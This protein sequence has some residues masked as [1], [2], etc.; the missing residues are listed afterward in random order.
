MNTSHARP[1]KILNA[2]AGSGKT[3]HLVKEYLS[4]LINDDAPANSFSHVIAMTFTNKAALEM[5]ERII[6]A[7][8][9]IASPDYFQ[10]RADALTQELSK[11]LNLDPERIRERCKESL[12]SILHQYEEFHVM[13]ID[14]FNLRLIK[15]FVRDL[16]LPS[17]FEVI[18]DE[19][20]L[21]EIIVDNLLSQLGTDGSK[22]LNRLVFQY[23][24]TNIEEGVQ[25]NFRQ[26]LIEFGAVLK[27]ERNTKTIEQLMEMDFSI[28]QFGRI[29]SQLKEIDSQFLQLANKL[30]D[31]IQVNSL[32]SDQLP[33]KSYTY[34]AILDLHNH[35]RFPIDKKPLVSDS[36]LKNLNIELKKGQWYPDEIKTAIRALLQ[37]W[38]DHFENYI[39]LHLFRQNFFNMALLK[40]IAEALANAR[41]EQQL[42]RISEFNTLISQLIQNESTPFIYERLGNK[43]HHFLLDEFQ[44]TSRLQWLNLVPLIKE[45]ISQNKD[46]LIVGDPKQSIYRFKNGVAEQFVALPAIYNPENDAQV[47]QHSHYFEQMG[48]VHELENN[49]RSSPTIVHFNNRFFE[50]LRGFLPEETSAFYNSIH[51]HPKSK[52]NGKIHVISKEEKRS[53]EELVPQ[54]IEWIED[55]LSNGY[56]PGEI[57][58]LGDTNR[59]CST[60]AIELNKRNY[61]VV[62][63]DSLLIHNNLKVQLSIAYLKRRFNPKGENEK[64]RFAELY[65]RINARSYDDYH[66]YIETKTS[67]KGKTYRIFNDVRF[68][69]DHFG[70]A[71]VFFFKYESLYDLIQQFYHLCG[72]NELKD[73]YLHHL[74][75]IAFEFGLKKGPD[76]KAFI[77]EYETKK[78]K[79][80]VQVP[81]S[82]EAIQLMTI[83]KSKG[84]EFP[85]V[86]VPS[87]NFKTSIK[88]KFLVQM[89]DYVVYKSPT[90]NEFLPVLKSLY[91]METAQIMGDNVNKCYVSMTRPVERLYVGNYYEKNK[92]GHVFHRVIQSMGL[93]TEIDG[94]LH[95]QTEDVERN[96]PKSSKSSSLF[97]PKNITEHL[98][99]PDI[100]LQDRD[101][102]TEDNY[103]S[104]EMQ[105]GL[106][107][108]LLASRIDHA[109]QIEHSIEKGIKEGEIDRAHKDGL[110]KKLHELLHLE[111]YTSLFSGAVQVLNEQ[112]IITDAQTTIRPD[113]IIL[114]ND[115]TII[116]D[117]KTGIPSSKD[118]KQILNYQRALEEM[119]YPSVQSYLFYAGIGELRRVG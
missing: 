11:E 65:F 42:I 78:N 16:D 61:Q 28:E 114:R 23:A 81:E 32:D 64:R 119:Q 35:E 74:A 86:I 99:F 53:P 103:L 9:M 56:Q 3:Y 79:I 107:F 100:A 46:N 14:K 97:S 33:G 20:E 94:A 91:D 106:Q 67:K 116:I 84:L 110:A 26:N 117:Y 80:A 24:K 45:S 85:V 21:I 1:L 69:T 112:D 5:K 88:S 75:D 51:Q 73:P 27:N 82:N 92:F 101:K 87:M 63:S 54:I 89:D 111:A 90:S 44:D 40:H 31:A 8:D 6:T 83:H 77:K 60:W 108:H 59:E 15:S 105:F 12:Q 70:S 113:K 10:H 19:T 96:L 72:Y 95:Y 17:E 66:Q 37:F 18:L 47:Q 38:E 118:E 109:S 30:K 57:C 25:W 93:G 41:K 2:S 29:M 102:L 43:F 36:F 49:W 22:E 68:L 115:A 62:S 48:K 39:S 4:L 76:L 34:K 98:W 52:A 104:D 13:T 58:I 50:T 55:C 7:L 71:E